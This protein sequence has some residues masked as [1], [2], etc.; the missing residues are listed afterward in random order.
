MEN[1]HVEPIVKQA[2]PLEQAQLADGHLLIRG[3]GCPNCA[4]RVRNSLLSLEGVVDAIVDHNI[5]AGRVI[6]NPTLVTSHELEGAVRAAGGD[7]RHEY[8]GKLV[9]T[10]S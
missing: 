1:C 9:P 4:A 6:Y 2:T 8:S 5:G 3:M 7:G 10:E